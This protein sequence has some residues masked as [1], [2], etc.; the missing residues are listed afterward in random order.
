MKITRSLALVASLAIAVCSAAAYPDLKE[1]NFLEKEI[2]LTDI[3]YRPMDKAHNLSAPEDLATFSAAVELQKGKNFS[4]A[5]KAYK[6]LFDK[7]PSDYV[8]AY[9]LG[10]CLEYQG[11]FDEAIGVLK[12]CL[13][14]SGDRH[15][16]AAKHLANC[17][18]MRAASDLRAASSYWHMFTSS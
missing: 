11:D 9:N 13:K 3:D 1:F 4:G 17:F 12:A 5:S 18:M 10:V 15:M 2:K 16:T 8:V 6:P 7:S 14:A